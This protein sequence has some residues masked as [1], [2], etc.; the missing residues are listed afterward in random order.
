MDAQLDTGT[1]A[2]G[3]TKVLDSIAEFLGIGHII[4]G[5]PGD[6]LGVS[7]IKLQ[8][9]TERDRGQ[10][11]QLVGCINTFYVESRVG[12]GIAEFLRLGEHVGEVTAL[13]THFGG[14][15]LAQRLDDRDATGNGSLERDHDPLLACCG[16]NLIAVQRN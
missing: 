16:K 2:S 6:A 3:D 7:A 4:A 12:L 5:D 10:D 8:R 13:V 15:S 1:I 14:Q 9:N 11:G